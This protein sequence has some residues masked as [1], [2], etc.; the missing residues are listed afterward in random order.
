MANKDIEKEEV[1]TQDDLKEKI[2]DYFV[3]VTEDKFTKIRVVKC[4]HKIE[5]SGLQLQN[6]FMTSKHWAT[7]NL[8]LKMDYRHT[9]EVDNVFFVFTYA[10]TG[11][12]YPGMHNLRLY[13]LI[14]DD[15]TIELNDVSGNDTSSQT[16]QVGDTYHNIYVET[17]QLSISAADF[18]QIA[19]ANKLEYSIRTGQG[20]LDGTF[21]EEQLNIIKG[22]YNAALDEDFEVEEISSFIESHKSKS[23]KN[24]SGCYI[25]TMAYGSYEH[26]QVIVLRDFRDN[27]LS[28]RDWGKKF[29]A[30]YYKY[31]P[32]LV[33]NLKNKT[34][35]N[36][37]ARGILNLFI[38]AI[39]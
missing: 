31:S 12:G 39:K 14:D 34:L 16:T 24:K 36:R 15:K 35:I 21:T 20:R 26:P 30:T 13:L 38:K 1:V 4:N 23:K 27:Y 32:R 11:G 9:E 10:N 8:D 33:E 6:A 25:A 5:W 18:I 7:H 19:N 3:T 28:K 17:A 29:I 22:F 2:K 37:L